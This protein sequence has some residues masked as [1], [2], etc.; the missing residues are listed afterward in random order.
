MEPQSRKHANLKWYKNISTR[1]KIL[2]TAFVP[3]LVFGAGNFILNSTN[4]HAN[5]ESE[6]VRTTPHSKT[7][8]SKNNAQI[9][10]TISSQ[11]A[12]AASIASSQLASQKAAQEAA[13]SSANEES[14]KSS[15]PASQAVASQNTNVSK[16]ESPAPSSEPSVNQS[17]TPQNNTQAPQAAPTD[18]SGFNFAGRHFPIAGFAGTGQVPADNNVYQWASDSR[19][20][21]IEQGGAAG[22]IIKANIHMG[23]AV[24]VNGRTYHVTD[25]VGGISNNGT[26][27][28]YYQ[29]H[30]GQHAI[31]FQTCDYVGVLTLYFA[32]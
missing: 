11:K 2:A 32:D 1:T 24:T 13:K 20:F 5:A 4:A 17:N 29:E 8:A 16:V 6:A 22:Q 12:E 25:L 21:L 14:A 31:G 10:Q 9:I 30:I 3:I 15:E 18:T 23:S 7:A 19:W 28:R 26:A 27:G